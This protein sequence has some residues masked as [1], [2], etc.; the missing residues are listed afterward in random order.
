[1]GAKE[2]ALQEL[3]EAIVEAREKGC[4]L[5]E[6][7]AAISYLRLSDDESEA[8][9]ALHEAV[10]LCEASEEPAVLREARRL[11]A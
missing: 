4:L 11:L 10:S 7:K 1:M 2:V 3:R 6:L 5:M 8:R 9:A